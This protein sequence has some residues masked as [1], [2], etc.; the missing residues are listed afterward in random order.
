MAYLPAF[1][2]RPSKKL[3]EVVAAEKVIDKLYVMRNELILLREGAHEFSPFSSSL[4]ESY[5]QAIQAIQ[6][7]MD[8]MTE[9]KEEM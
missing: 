1:T 3:P 6:A 5:G 9:I 7:T 8:M 2:P 4:F